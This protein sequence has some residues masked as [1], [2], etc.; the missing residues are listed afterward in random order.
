MSTMAT[1]SEGLRRFTRVSVLAGLCA[2]FGSPALA[3]FSGPPQDQPNMAVDAALRAATVD[4]LAAAVER[5]YVFPDVATKTAAALRAKLKKGAYSG[6]DSAVAS[7]T[8]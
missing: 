1:I 6:L 2:L 5:G 3:Q 4:S 8:H 7:A